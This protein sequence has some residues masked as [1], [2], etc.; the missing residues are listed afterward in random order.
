MRKLLRYRFEL[1]FLLKE[2]NFLARL[3][4]H[5]RVQGNLNA[6]AF[7]EFELGIK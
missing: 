7:L 5:L 1:D 2:F 4:F 3:A 6:I